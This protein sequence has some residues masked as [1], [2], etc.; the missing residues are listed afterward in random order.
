ME[1][2]RDT[3]SISSHPGVLRNMGVQEIDASQIWIQQD[4]T[5]DG[6]TPELM[7]PGFDKQQIMLGFKSLERRQLTDFAV[8]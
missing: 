1:Q 5:E 8:A 7:A 2:H 6:I 4:G 3:L